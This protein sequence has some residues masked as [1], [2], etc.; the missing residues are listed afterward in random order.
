LTQV[1]A[2]LL[3]RVYSADMSN[4]VLGG[5]GSSLPAH[6]SINMNRFTLVDDAG[7]ERP[8]SMHIDV[9]IVSANPAESRVFY[10]P[11]RGYDP[12]GIDNAPPICF[13]DNGTGPSRNAPL[14]QSNL[15][16][17]CSHAVWGSKISQMTGKGVPACQKNKKIA[18]L[19]PGD[20]DNIA[21]MFKIPPASLTALAQYVK[22][23]KGHLINGRPCQV[24]DV[25]T[26]L[27]FES[28]G[29]VKFTPVGMVDEDTFNR[30]EV[31][32]Q[33]TP[34][35]LSYLTGRDD[36]ARDPALALPAPPVPSMALPAGQQAQA[37]AQRQAPPPQQAATAKPPKPP[38][39][40]QKAQQP[41]QLDIPD[42]LR[43]QGPTATQQNPSA[44]VTDAPPPPSDM[45][46]AL[47]SAFSLPGVA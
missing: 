17:T 39:K 47:D 6:L 3:N 14:P 40:D 45:Q 32:Y 27:E 25:I 9:C 7:N 30:T 38:K 24:S 22:T 43:V 28:Q 34:E 21:F 11:S 29:V 18:F 20:A 31:I 46:A 5:I 42:F 35:R 26:R 16:G 10:D 44:G 8:P 36:V 2:Y 23:L 19:V 37:P 15:C 4:D 13:S 12:R 33:T 41:D 1:P